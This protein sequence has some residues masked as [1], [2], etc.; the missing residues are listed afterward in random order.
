MLRGLKRRKVNHIVEVVEVAEPAP[1]MRG[2]K[3]RGTDTGAKLA[4]GPDRRAC[5]AIEGIETHLEYFRD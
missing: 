5:P 4:E 1:M 2:L 3:R